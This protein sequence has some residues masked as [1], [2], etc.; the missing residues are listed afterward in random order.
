MSAENLSGLDLAKSKYNLVE[1]ISASETLWDAYTAERSAVQKKFGT[2][3]S[4]K[5]KFDEDDDRC[6]AVCDQTL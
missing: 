6:Y 3:L 4:D 5:E 1:P 2:V